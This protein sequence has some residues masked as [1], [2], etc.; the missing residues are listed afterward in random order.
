MLTAVFQ[1]FAGVCLHW[2]NQSTGSFKILTIVFFFF[3]LV[4]NDVFEKEVLIF[5]YPV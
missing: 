1:T 2:I 3:F 5:T 4:F